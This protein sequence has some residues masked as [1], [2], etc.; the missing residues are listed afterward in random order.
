MT[1]VV[2]GRPK[3]TFKVNV[4]MPPVVMKIVKMILLIMMILLRFRL[5]KEINSRE[6][7]NDHGR[8]QHNINICTYLGRKNV[9]VDVLYL[10]CPIQS[11]S[12]HVDRN[13]MLFNIILILKFLSSS[14]LGT[15]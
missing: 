15:F 7:N 1:P 4:A 14:C 13:N 9:T 11:V 5:N 8:P 3:N 10:V 6:L 2:V 12:C